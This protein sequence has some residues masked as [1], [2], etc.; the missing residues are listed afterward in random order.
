[1]KAVQFLH[2]FLLLA[3]ACTKKSDNNTT[4]S[5]PTINPQNPKG[6]CLTVRNDTATF[7]A[8]TTIGAR[9]NVPNTWNNII[10]KGKTRVSGNFI[11]SSPNRNFVI[12]GEDSETSILDGSGTAYVKADRSLCN[13]RFENQGT[14]LL[15]NFTSLNP[16]NF[17]ITA[18]APLTIVKMRIIENRRTTS[19]D[20]A[21]STKGLTI[22]SS[23]ISTYD[24]VLYVGECSSISNTIIEHNKNG[25]P[26]MNSWGGN[27]NGNKTIATNVTIRD[28]EDATQGY[29]HG[30]VGWAQKN[31]AGVQIT[32]IEFIN[33]QWIVNPDKI[34]CAEFY[35]FGNNGNTVTDGKVIQIGGK[36]TW[37]TPIR[38]RNGS[39]GIVTTQ[40]C[41]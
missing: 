22:D 39:N 26:F 3:V 17:H 28:N 30:V 41:N 12:K 25:A 4:S 29:A 21:H 31:D 37:A 16:A 13:V 24:D 40:N 1:M 11:I 6:W 32:T 2:F 38:Q 27:A 5:T 8:D 19:T 7:W 18:W 34:K 15:Y 9:F 23:Y 14:L 33:C 20:A 36:C 35:S 10:I